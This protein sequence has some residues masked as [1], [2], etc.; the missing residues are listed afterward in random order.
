MTTLDDIPDDVLDTERTEG[1]EF[2]RWSLFAV[3][4]G[5]VMGA[6]ATAGGLQTLVA[7]STATVAVAAS[8]V[9][10]LVLYGAYRLSEN[11]LLERAAQRDYLETQT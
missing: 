1:R 10:C 6:F 5:S 9:G 8:G 2:V 3:F 7:I 11:W 4:F